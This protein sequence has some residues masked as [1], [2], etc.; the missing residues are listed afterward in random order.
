M[1]ITSS[2]SSSWSCS[3]QEE[4]AAHRRGEAHFFFGFQCLFASSY[5]SLL[6][7]FFF[8]FFYIQC[9]CSHFHILLLFLLFKNTLQ[10]RTVWETGEPNLNVLSFFFARYN[11]RIKPE[12]HADILWLFPERRAAPEKNVR[13]FIHHHICALEET[14]IKTEKV[15]LISS[16]WFVS[17]GMNKTVD[18]FIYFS[19]LR[20]TILFCFTFKLKHPTKLHKLDFQPKTD[21][22]DI[23]IS[24]YPSVFSLY[25]SLFIQPNK[26]CAPLPHWEFVFL[27]CPSTSF[28]FIFSLFI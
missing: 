26:P 20:F 25:S 21:R 3:P 23:D 19:A 24:V 16:H 4:A 14:T 27:L 28:I 10:K 2:C 15:N 18:L 17:H 7:M 13:C 9:F 6:V 11:T 5:V 22:T 8:L 12:I 1:I